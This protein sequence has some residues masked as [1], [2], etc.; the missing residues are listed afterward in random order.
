MKKIVNKDEGYVL[1]STLFFLLL[2]GLFSYSVIQIS[3]NYVIQLRQVS[4]GY[5][6]KAALNMSEELL[7]QEFEGRSDPINGTIST[8]AGEVKIK[9][10]KN[11]NQIISQLTLVKENGN[12]YKKDITTPLS[13]IEE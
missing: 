12:I 13:L 2:S 5:E 4:L 6:A 11:G 10:R 1:I 8:S 3:S 7:L 9:G